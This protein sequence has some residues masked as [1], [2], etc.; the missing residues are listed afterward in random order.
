MPNADE[1][2]PLIS[3]NNDPLSTSHGACSNSSD[4][5]RNQIMGRGRKFLIVAC[6]LATELCERLTYYGLRANLLLFCSSELKLDPPWPSTISYLFSGWCINVSVS[7]VNTEVS[8][9]SSQMVGVKF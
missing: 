3:E 5:N 2:S 7:Y 6:I 8:T 9:C 1:N 4:N